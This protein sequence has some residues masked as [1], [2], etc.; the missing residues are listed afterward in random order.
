M[1]RI[2][3]ILLLFFLMIS[4][5]ENGTNNLPLTENFKT[6]SVDLGTVDSLE[7]GKTY[8]SVYSR[9]YSFT[10]QKT[11]NLTVTASIRNTSLSDTVYISKAEYYNSHGKPIQSYLD[12][13]IYI[14]PL[15]TIEIVIDE[16]D[17]KGGT[18]ANF[19]FEW[20]K[21][22]DTS[23][24]LFEGVMIST[25]GTQGLSFTTQGIRIE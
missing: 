24:P 20:K 9:I 23:E 16:V 13:P 15:E 5:Q 25:Y 8:L 22:P 19:I 10:E 3:S 14:A 21:K 7:S 12:S 6:R 11:H 2:I 18:G 17:Q 4:C 1:K